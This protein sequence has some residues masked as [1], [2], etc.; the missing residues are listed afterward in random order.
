[1]DPES[2]A[3]ELPAAFESSPLDG[4]GILPFPMHFICRSTVHRLRQKANV[5]QEHAVNK[6]ETQAEGGLPH[7]NKDINKKKVADKIAAAYVD[8]VSLILLT[9]SSCV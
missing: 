9:A 2:P 3:E 8:E 6:P 5:Y 1:M 7:A 4:T